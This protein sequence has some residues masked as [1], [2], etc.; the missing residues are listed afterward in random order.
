MPLRIGLAGLGI[1]GMR[2]AEHLL[3]GDVPR[4]VLTAVT[5]R[6]A[7]AGRTWAAARGIAYVGDPGELVDHPAVDA[8]VAVL[9]P[10]LHPGL[11]RACLARGKP[12]LVEKPLAA[13]AASAAEVAALVRETGVLL[14]VGHTLRFDPLVR[15][16]KDLARELG[17]LRVLALNQRFEP[18]D[19]AWIDRPGPGG[20]LLNT[21]V[22]GFDLMRFL[23]GAEAQSVD[24]QVEAVV[25]V[26]TEDE[27]MAL[28]R[29]VPGPILATLDN[30]RTTAGRS[31]R[32]EIVGEQGQLWGDH[33]HRGLF[34]V[35]GREQESLGPIPAVP[36]VA[37]TL[38]AFVDAVLDGS[39]VPCTAED[40]LQA[41]RMAEAAR[42]SA[43]TGRRQYLADVSAGARPSR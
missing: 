38:S 19:R 29:L 8:V 22:H 5:R 34:R 28:V 11:A 14:M 25:T 9:P 24:A 30:A 12:V 21:A 1:H 6:D 7:T 27:V 40:G 41:V 16:L 20:A 31:G 39:P 32:I 2:Y 35:R 43:E 18:T 10:D 23:T 26:R 3:R 13:D 33:V 4:A 42:R 36:T 37:A 17:P 15:R